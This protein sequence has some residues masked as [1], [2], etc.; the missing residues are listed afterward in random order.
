MTLI[1][2]LVVAVLCLLFGPARVIAGLSVLLLLL[3]AVVILRAVASMFRAQ[4]M[5]SGQPLSLSYIT[6]LILGRV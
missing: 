2:L 1:A 5:L 3:A 6:R 4:T